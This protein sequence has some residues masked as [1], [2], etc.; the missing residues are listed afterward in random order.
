MLALLGVAALRAHAL[1]LDEQTLFSN[2]DGGYACYNVPTLTR[3]AGSTLVACAEGRRYGCGDGGY[4][5]IMCRRSTDGGV[6]W[7]SASR[8]PPAVLP[9]GN[10]TN[11]DACVVADTRGVLH[12]VHMLNNTRVYYRNS[13]T[14]GA[15]WSAPQDITFA[16]KPS[17]EAAF[18]GTGHASGTAVAMP[19]ASAPRLL[20]PAYSAGQAFMVVTDTLG[21]EWYHSSAVGTGGE[22]QAVVIGG[23]GHLWMNMRDN[24][25][26][27]VPNRRLSSSSKDGGLTWSSPTPIAGI[28][29]PLWGCE[30]S[31]VCTPNGTLYYSGPEGKVLRTRMGVWSSYDQGASWSRVT[32]VWPHA[33]GYSAMVALDDEHLV[34]AYA[35][36]VRTRVVFQSTNITLV[37][38]RL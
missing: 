5:D 4:V 26:H 24:D 33:A 19:A 18:M 36:S 32:D 2:G 31:T 30:G 7:S 16:A 8:V 6:S 34:L 17:A 38:V 20:F 35:R 23:D 25:R 27:A 14:V 1:V 15:D 10:D 13:T 37:R 9:R 11:G 12:M 22:G 29:S 3:V 28:F 21:D